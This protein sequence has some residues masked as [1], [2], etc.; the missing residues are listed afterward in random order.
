MSIYTQLIF[1]VVIFAIL[2]FV[3]TFIVGE[4]LHRISER[5]R[6][7]DNKEM[8][9]FLQHMHIESQKNTREVER[10][11]ASSEKTLQDNALFLRMIFERVDKP[12]SNPTA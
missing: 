1:L 9:S 7:A 3:I 12:D 8:Q 2:T 5:S 4:V 10:I 11:L 6:R